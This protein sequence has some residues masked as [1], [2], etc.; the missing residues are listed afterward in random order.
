[1]RNEDDPRICALVS[2]LI[3]IVKRRVLQAM[4]HS[5]E[6]VEFEVAT[7]ANLFTISQAM[8][9]AKES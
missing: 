1:M 7:L 9:C 6:D 2:Q 8:N 3:P 5:R 4:E